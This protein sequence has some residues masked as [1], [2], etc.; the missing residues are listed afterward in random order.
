MLFEHFVNCLLA[1]L[2]SRRWRK[3][4][5]Y[6]ALTFGLPCGLLGF[7]VYGN[8]IPANVIA[9]RYLKNIDLD[10]ERRLE[11]TRI[12]AEVDDSADVHV[13]LNRI[14]QLGNSSP[15]VVYIVA[16]EMGKQG[17]VASAARKMRE[18][19]PK[20]GSGFPD[21][22]CWLAAYGASQPIRGEAGLL[23][24]L[25]DFQVAN[26]GMAFLPPQLVVSYAELLK[27]AGR[28]KQA[29]DL[30][31]LR[32]EQ[33]P[34]L[35]PVLAKLAAAANDRVQMRVAISKTN[36]LLLER[37]KDQPFDEAYFLQQIEL[38]AIQ[39][40]LPAVVKIAKEGVET[41]PDSKLLR[42]QLSS[43]LIVEG[44]VAAAAPRP[45]RPVGG[46]PS[47]SSSPVE[48][49]DAEESGLSYLDAAYQMD[50]N[51]QLVMHRV[52]QA[53][54]AGQDLSPE[55]RSA[56]EA[57]LADGT[58]SGFTHLTLGN[59]RLQQGDL[60]RAVEHLEIALEMLPG[61][62]VVQNN[63]AYAYLQLQPPAIEKAV[64]LVDAALSVN[65][66]SASNRASI[67]DTQGTAFMLKGD[68]VGAIN[69][70]EDAVRLDPT[71]LH[72]RKQLVLLFE[73]LGMADMAKAQSDL[74]DELERRQ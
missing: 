58:A 2:T 26:E 12:G 15:R 33:S 18:I 10:I 44:D 23:T 62:V 59:H 39:R 46:I 73:K 7:V 29:I 68:M 52:V 50:P 3:C 40:D 49:A 47:E 5:L 20:D 43:A 13:E 45:L 36:E 66:V 70:F 38:A 17:R 42:R 31:T 64:E 27:I 72:S 9:G 61:A 53:I 54:V 4:L 65:G 34:A 1:W 71:K 24:L 69:S 37:Y 25:N 22:H 48:G 11:A 74:I 35:Y 19:A 55:L 16:I 67:L 60:T 8:S 56:L 6:A 28:T 63:L 32:A 41:F 30:L 14:L 51:N 57:R 21:A